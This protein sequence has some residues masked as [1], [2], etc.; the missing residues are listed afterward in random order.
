MCTVQYRSCAEQGCSKAFKTSVDEKK[1]IRCK[2]IE[3]DGTLVAG[4]CQQGLKEEII[5]YAMHPAVL[6]L[7]QPY[8]EV[9]A[10]KH[11][12]GWNAMDKRM[13]EMSQVEEQAP[14][15]SQ[16]AGGS[17]QAPRGSQT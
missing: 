11:I 13:K 9:H 15:E 2:Q 14:A 3:N 17:G 16:G 1:T 5:P 8:C 6:M 4:Q 7:V 12:Q 10:R